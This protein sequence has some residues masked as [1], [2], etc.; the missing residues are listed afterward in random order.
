MTDKE[1]ETQLEAANRRGLESYVGQV[2]A[3]F[4]RYDRATSNLVLELRGGLTL[5]VPVGLLQG[6][7]NA[8]PE[9]IE[10]VEL[11]SNGAALHWE[12]LDADFSIQ[13]IAAGSFGMIPWM[14]KLEETGQ[15]DTASIERRRIVAELQNPTAAAM[16]RKGGAARSN[17]KIEA[18]RANG[19]KGGRPRKKELTPA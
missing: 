19:A 3:T 7:A 5:L 8:A 16:G 11:V 18:A 15:L 10:R 13:S 2:H 1:F 6:V 9:L 14:Q 4:A 12:E 17:A